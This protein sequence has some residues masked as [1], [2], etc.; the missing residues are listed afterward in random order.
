MRDN[1]AV[2]IDMAT[3]IAV[4]KNDLAS[5]APVSAFE[6]AVISEAK[7]DAPASVAPV[8]PRSGIE[9]PESEAAPQAPFDVDL[10]KVDDQ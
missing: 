3:K 7:R 9:W 4:L 5:R 10:S 1:A 6:Q 8:Y 2:E